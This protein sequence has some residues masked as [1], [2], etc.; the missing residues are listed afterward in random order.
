MSQGPF[1]EPPTSDQDVDELEQWIADWNDGEPGDATDTSSP[2]APSAEERHALPRRARR[3]GHGLLWVTATELLTCG[4]LLFWLTAK[5]LR[6]PEPDLVVLTFALWPFVL[7][8]IALTL[9]NRRGT[10]R[11]RNESVRAFLELERLRIERQL[12]TATRILPAIYGVEMAMILPWK[13]WSL[14]T[15]QPDVATTRFLEVVAICTALSLALF[16]GLWWWQRRLLERRAGLDTLA[17]AFGDD[18]E[19][20]Y[21][22]KE[23]SGID[24]TNEETPGSNP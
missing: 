7:G 20:P 2:E 22:G 14:T 4:G 16:A 15:R 24:S 12:R 8:T 1:T 23:P 10:W 3:F 21:H 9:W 18:G 19:M 5:S 6:H 17:D 13:W 11:P